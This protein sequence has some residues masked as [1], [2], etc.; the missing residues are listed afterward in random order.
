MQMLCYLLLMLKVKIDGQ[1]VNIV[2]CEHWNLHSIIVDYYLVND[3][4]VMMMMM[5]M[6]YSLPL[7]VLWQFYID[8]LDLISIKIRQ[9]TMRRP[10]YL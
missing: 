7:H 2:L 1:L 3:D 5:M 10:G 8:Q 4:D 6:N 9:V